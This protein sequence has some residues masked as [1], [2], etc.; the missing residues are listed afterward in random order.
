[1]FEKVA[2]SVDPFSSNPPPCPHAAEGNCPL[3]KEDPRGLGH[4]SMITLGQCGECPG[5]NE[6]DK[7]GDHH[8]GG[9]YREAPREAR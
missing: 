8:F 2:T 1:M 5:F 6:F 9:N 7:W 4:M 3:V